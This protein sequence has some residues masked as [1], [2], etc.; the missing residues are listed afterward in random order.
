LEKDLSD[1]DIMTLDLE[2]NNGGRTKELID[3]A[4]QAVADISI[5]RK[6]VFL[7]RLSLAKIQW[8]FET[9]NFNDAAAGV[10]EYF[11]RGMRI[12]NSIANDFLDLMKNGFSIRDTY[13]KDHQNHK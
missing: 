3:F 10:A 5:D 13:V 6:E 12:N 4:I 11:N 8:S 1:R 2:L 9:G 7:P